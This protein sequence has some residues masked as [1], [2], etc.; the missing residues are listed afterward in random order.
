ME[1]RPVCLDAEDA[2]ELGE[3]LEV[4]GDWLCAERTVLA[5]SLRRFLGVDG[6]DTDELC[7]DL[8]RFAFLLGVGDGESL[9]GGDAR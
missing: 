9:F 2:V 1:L 3:L 6:Y 5:G 8:A 7:A 4:L